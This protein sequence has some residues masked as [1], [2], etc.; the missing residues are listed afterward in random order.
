MLRQPFV[1]PA[2]LILALSIPLILGLIPRNRVYGVRTAKTIADDGRWYRANRFGGWALL[3]SSIM[4]LIV[5]A[6]APTAP[7]PND[8]LLVWLLHLGAFVGPLVVSLVLI[9]GYIKRL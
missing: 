5:M 3:L 2:L 9:R 1:V 8:S 7:P 6:L 4:Y